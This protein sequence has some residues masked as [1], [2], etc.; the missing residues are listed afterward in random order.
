VP[1]RFRLRRRFSA[2]LARAAAPASRLVCRLTDGGYLGGGATPTSMMGDLGRLNTSRCE[3]CVQAE[4]LNVWRSNGDFQCR[5][6]ALL[7][8]H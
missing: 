1:T 3:I 7:H 5:I 8:L 6:A 4:H 2:T